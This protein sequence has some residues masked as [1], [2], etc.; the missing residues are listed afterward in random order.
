MS[1]VRSASPSTRASSEPPL[2]REAWPIAA[3]RSEVRARSS[4]A[5][6]GEWWA[7]GA[8][9]GNA[10][11]PATPAPAV[12]V[13]GRASISL[14]RT[15]CDE[16]RAARDTSNPSS[17]DVSL[18]PAGRPRPSSCECGRSD[19]DGAR[20]SKSRRSLTVAGL[21]ATAGPSRDARRLGDSIGWR[22][23][24]LPNSGHSSGTAAA[25]APLLRCQ[26]CTAFVARLSL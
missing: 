22:S 17:A 7:K 23:V 12:R 25:P 4:S 14:D 3:H 2:S 20:M 16:G 21:P 15:A 24:S 10:G 13:C 1:V 11:C 26:W 19:H 8:T 9:H 5:P 6:M 18:P